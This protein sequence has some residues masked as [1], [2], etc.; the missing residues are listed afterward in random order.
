MLVKEHQRFY[1]AV[2]SSIYVRFSLVGRGHRGKQ[3]ILVL[4]CF[5][6]EKTR[7]LNEGDEFNLSLTHEE[8]GSMTG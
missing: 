8:P 3:T 5:L 1:C 7:D 4:F 2:L 6:L